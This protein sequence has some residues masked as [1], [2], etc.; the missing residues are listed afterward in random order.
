MNFN[1]PELNK[2]FRLTEDWTFILYDEYRNT[3]LIEKFGR[4]Y[5]WGTKTVETL[6]KGLILKVRKIY[7]KSGAS[8]FSSLTFTCPKN[9]NKA[10][11]LAN[12]Q[13]EIYGGTTF[14][15]KLR[16][17]NAAEIE[18]IEKNNKTEGDI[19][20]LINYI[21]LNTTINS[22]SLQNMFSGIFANGDNF[23]NI[24][25]D[26][27]TSTYMTMLLNNLKHKYNYDPM[28]DMNNNKESTIVIDIINGRLREYK[29][30]ELLN[31][32]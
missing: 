12:P 4:K 1:I 25:T 26:K 24:Q 15:A 11:K 21:R 28:I 5:V 23:N 17:V 22:S 29:L 6:P 10:E 16:D 30:K 32:I 19:L 20:E 27:D 3:T 8:E 18:F 2:A 7:I 13:N 31:S 9:K 14:W